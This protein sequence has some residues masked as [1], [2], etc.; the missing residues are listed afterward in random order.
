MLDLFLYNEKG[1]KNVIKKCPHCEFEPIQDQLICPNC[2]AELNEN[3]SEEIQ[4][5]QPVVEEINDNINWSNYQDIPLGSVMEHF[6]EVIEEEEEPVAEEVSVEGDSEPIK[7]EKETNDSASIEEDE[8]SDNP[9]LAAYIRRHREGLPEDELL[10]AIEKNQEKAEEITEEII[11]NEEASA[12]EV[13][14]MLKV[15]ESTD[16]LANQAKSETSQDIEENLEPTVELTETAPVSEETVIEDSHISEID[17]ALSLI[18]QF[19]EKAESEKTAESVEVVEE[20]EV[21][22]QVEP[23]IVREEPIDEVTSDIILN[24]SEVESKSEATVSDQPTPSLKKNRQKLIYTLTAAGLIAVASGGWMYYDAQQKAE[25]ARQEQLRIDSELTEAKA[26]LL[27][28]YLADDH[29]FVKPDKTLAMLKETQKKLEP[30]RSEEAY[31]EI[32]PIVQDLYTKLTKIESLNSY[33]TAPIIVGNQLVKDVHIKDESPIVIENISGEGSF[34]TLFNE[35]LQYGKIE[36]QKV[37]SAKL[38][39]EDISRFYQDEKLDKALTRKDFDMAKKQVDELFDISTKETLQNQLKPIEKALATREEQEKEA[40]RIAAE[41][42]AEEERQAALQQQYAA[43]EILSP[44][45]PTNRNNQPIISSRQSDINDV[46]NPA[47]FW[48][49]GVY[50]QVIDTLMSRGNIV[51]GRFYVVPAR[52][53]NGEGYYHLYA[54]NAS[55]SDTYLVTIN[56]KTGYF[57]GNGG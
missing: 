43:S 30:Y 49:P 20:V 28:F 10:A 18:S 1:V 57:K 44:N 27:D 42:K 12:V 41:K 17:K 45:T 14:E 7:E 3:I 8:L 48:A 51:A 25:A 37:T 35:A 31:T 56:A 34:A 11:S 40:A 13:E 47:W 6:N 21:A 36:V 39:V 19:E 22:E 4:T 38:A 15:T 16:E 5:T 23:V 53:E 52:I 33:F 24:E 55:K 29:E 9:I 2:G 50:D 26:Q 32:D 54:T 46:N